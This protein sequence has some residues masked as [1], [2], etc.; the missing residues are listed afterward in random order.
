MIEKVISTRP[1]KKIRIRR[2][3]ILGNFYNLEVEMVLAG[4]EGNESIVDTITGITPDSILTKKGRL[5]RLS[6]IQ[7]IYQL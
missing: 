4:N 5:I 6:T 7:T 2:A 3:L 1:R